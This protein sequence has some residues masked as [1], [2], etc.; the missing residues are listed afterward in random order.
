M[1]L[2]SPRETSKLLAYNRWANARMLE[3]AAA[4]SDE[5]WDRQLGGSFGSLHGTLTHVYAGEWVWLERASGRSP[6]SLPA[7]ED[8]PTPGAL[9]AA[10]RS[11]ED[12]IAAFAQGLS[13][14]D[15]ARPVTYANFVGENWT[16]TVADILFDLVNHSTYHRGQV[17]TLLRQLGKT[18]VSTDYVLFLNSGGVADPDRTPGELTRLFAYNRWANMRMRRSVSEIPAED[19]GRAVGGSFSTLRDTLVHLYG[20]DWVWLERVSGRSPRALPE[21][22][23]AETPQ[24]LEQKWRGVEEGWAALVD[25]IEPGRMRERLDYTNFKGDALSYCVGEILVH[26]VNHSTYHR[27]QVATLTRQLGRKP[28]STDY[29]MMLDEGA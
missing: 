24:A 26:L 10:W 5:E 11:L 25:E 17:V 1:M 7:P 20:A 2:R 4:V 21:G 23:Q 28:A 15:L 29:L 12:G 16:Y 22:Q 6:K 14:A 8:L 13:P 3:P 19:Y 27:G 9:R 18:P